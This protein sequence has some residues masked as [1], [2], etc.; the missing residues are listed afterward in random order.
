MTADAVNPSSSLLEEASATT[1]T[2]ED[3][4][5]EVPAVVIAYG[6]ELESSMVQSLMRSGELTSLWGLPHFSC[7]SNADSGIIRAR[8]SSA[9]AR[10]YMARLSVF[11]RLICPSV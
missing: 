7:S 11:N 9:F 3:A 4:A 2:F 1:I 10:P 5:V 6:F 8:S